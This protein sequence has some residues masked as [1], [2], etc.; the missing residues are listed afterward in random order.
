MFEKNIKGFG[1]AIL[2]G[3]DRIGGDY[4]IWQLTG[5]NWQQMPGHAVGI[6]G[7]GNQPMVVNSLGQIFRW[8]P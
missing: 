7:S 5:G 6:S 2:I 8:A 4:G 1:L 3:I